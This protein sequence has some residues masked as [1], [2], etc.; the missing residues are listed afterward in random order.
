MFD[1]LFQSKKAAVTDGVMDSGQFC[2]YELTDLLA[3]YCLPGQQRHD[4]LHDFAHIFG[5]GCASFADGACHGNASLATGG[6]Q[7]TNSSQ[8][9]T[10]AVNR[11]VA[12]NPTASLFLRKPAGLCT[13]GNPCSNAFTNP[14]GHSGG[15]QW[16]SPSAG[17][18]AASNWING[19][20]GPEALLL[21]R[22]LGAPRRIPV[23]PSTR[24]GALDRLAD[25]LLIRPR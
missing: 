7:F 22:T 2:F 10:F 12:N 13:A 4:R 20:M 1:R 23:N 17:F 3:I 11:S 9:F 15:S 8:A 16:A 18:T 24:S 5:S 19:G 6:R 14:N 25:S 21:T